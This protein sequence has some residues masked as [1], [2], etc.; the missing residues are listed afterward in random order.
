MYMA[1]KWAPERECVLFKA[2]SDESEENLR[3][4]LAVERGK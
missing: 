3:M 1:N 4:N 2:G